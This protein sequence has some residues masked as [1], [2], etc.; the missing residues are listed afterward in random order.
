MS[1]KHVNPG[2]RRAGAAAGLGAIGLGLLTPAPAGAAGGPPLTV[3][4][5]DCAE[6]IGLEHI[7]RG[8]LDGALPADFDTTYGFGDF[9]SVPPAD[10]AVIIVRTVNCAEH[11]INGVERGEVNLA[12]IGVITA[13]TDAEDLDAYPGTGLDNFQMEFVTDSP[14]LASAMNRAGANARVDPNLDIE[15][16]PTGA[17]IDASPRYEAEGIIGAEV[18]FPS[19]FIAHWWGRHGTTDVRSQQVITGMQFHLDFTGDVSVQAGNAGLLGDLIGND[20]VAYDLGIVGE[21]PEGNV[22]IEPANP[23]A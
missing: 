13:L 1:H 23:G 17:A 20:P 14:R 2:R 16:S 3:T 11:R 15:V 8:L 6:F 21:I 5:T 19:P 18:S 7:D 4:Y 10:V 12:Q 9:G 22:V